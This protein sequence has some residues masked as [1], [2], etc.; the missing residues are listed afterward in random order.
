MLSVLIMSIILT[1]CVTSEPLPD[2]ENIY[3]VVINV[4]GL[5]KNR[6]FLLAND[7]MVSNF[8]SAEAVIEY[9]DSEEGIIIGKAN[10]KAD[11]GGLV[12]ALVNFK[13][14]INVKDEKT[15]IRLEN[16]SYAST[17][18]PL[19]NALM[20]FNRVSYEAFIGWADEEIISDYRD[21]LHRNKTDEW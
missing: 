13:I 9:S 17:S 7:W 3:E 18:S 19:A 15:R 12:K 20:S 2:N 4:P 1:G 16:M 5:D 8:R 6:I 10:A 21:Y 11:A 14:T